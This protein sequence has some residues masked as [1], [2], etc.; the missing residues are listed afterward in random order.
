MKDIRVVVNCTNYDVTKLLIDQCII[1]IYYCL[2]NYN[3]KYR[4]KIIL[5]LYQWPQKYQIHLENRD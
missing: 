1:D 5:I 4:N 3:K 2:S